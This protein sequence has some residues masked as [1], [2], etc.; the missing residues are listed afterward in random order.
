MFALKQFRDVVD[1][2]KACYQSLV[3]V[4]RAF[5]EVVD[6]RE[7]EETLR[8]R[9][10]DFPTLNESYR[11]YRANLGEIGPGAMPA[12]LGAFAEQLSIRGL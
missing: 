2:A 11:F 9:I 7:I 6:L 8:V 4:S 1:P 12:P 5:E 3:R 10:H